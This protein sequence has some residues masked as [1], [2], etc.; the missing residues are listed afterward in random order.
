MA[1]NDDRSS[2]PSQGWTVAPID[3]PLRCTVLRPFV[4]ENAEAKVL[5]SIRSRSTVQTELPRDGL[6][7]PVVR[8][9]RSGNHVHF[10]R[11]NLGLAASHHVVRMDLADYRA[12]PHTRHDSPLSAHCY[13][14]IMSQ[15]MDR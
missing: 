10:L 1:A 8:A 6:G 13:A 14:Y 9:A 2:T 4:T 15:I 5:L 3:A 7:G 12:A 11:W